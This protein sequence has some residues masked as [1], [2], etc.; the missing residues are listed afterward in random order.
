MKQ[1]LETIHTSK[2]NIGKNI[3]KNSDF[4]PIFVLRFTINRFI[5]NK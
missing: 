2:M 1:S 5:L 4:R 3:L